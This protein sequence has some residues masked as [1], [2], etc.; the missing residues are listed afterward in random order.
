MAGNA[1]QQRVIE[2]RYRFRF[3]DGS[4][5]SFSVT[6]G[7]DTMAIVG[8]QRA[9]YPAWTDLA[10]HQCSNCPLDP[11]Q[12]PRCPIA[13][14]MVDAV[15]FLKDWRS[16]EQVETA[17]ESHNRCYQKR[18]S[19]QEAASALLGIFMVASGCPILSKLRPMLATHLP[20]MDPEESTYR[21]ISMYLMAQ[22]FRQRRGQRPDWDL[23]GL[24]RFLRECRIA[25]GGIVDRLR[26]LGIQDAALNALAVLNM[27][28]ELTSLSLAT[29][30]LDRWERVFEGH[31]KDDDGPIGAC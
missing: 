15:E 7:Y 5:R 20:F 14:E 17:V 26:S 8:R 4:E 21:T 23:T 12:H 25:N 19:L 29:G 3:P 16:Y 24:L 1:A 18:T 9:T 11:S 10:Y 13:A 28:G 6:L 22:Y 27:Q 30:E 2:F 31:M